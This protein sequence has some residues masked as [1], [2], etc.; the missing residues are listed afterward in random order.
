M[1]APSWGGGGRHTLIC[2][3]GCFS[4][5]GC[6]FCKSSL[7]LIDV[8]PVLRKLPTNPSHGSGLGEGGGEVVK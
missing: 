2:W 4:A 3:A 6:S 5:S 8:M 1:Q 7:V